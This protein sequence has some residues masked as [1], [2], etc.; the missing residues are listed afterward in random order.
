M[1]VIALALLVGAFVTG[2][3]IAGRLV[4]SIPLQLFLGFAFGVG[5]CAALVMTA[6][7]VAFAGCLFYGASG[8]FH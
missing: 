1:Q 5:L 6:F 2:F 3:L 7:G 4:K 8:S